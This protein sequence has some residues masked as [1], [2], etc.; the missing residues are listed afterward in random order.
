MK[1]HYKEP[2]RIFL[3][4]ACCGREL[5]LY[6]KDDLPERSEGMPPIE[7][8]RADVFEKALAERDEADRRA[9]CAERK[10][11]SSLEKI[12][13]HND[14][15]PDAASFGEAWKK[16]VLALRDIVETQER[17]IKHLCKR[18]GGLQKEIKRLSQPQK[19]FAKSQE[20]GPT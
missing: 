1:S 5:L 12:A 20:S 8:V 6:R 14:G 18:I 7:Y 10:L 4:P 13:K 2:E 19:E 16:E 15:A 3:P 9:G 11:A 17:Y